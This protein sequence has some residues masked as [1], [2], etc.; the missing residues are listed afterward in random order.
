M[1]ETQP[2]TRPDFVC[3][4]CH[5]KIDLKGERYLVEKRF[6]AP[7][8]RVERTGRYL[9][10]TCDQKDHPP[11]IWHRPEEPKRPATF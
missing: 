6:N 1:S 11:G 7:L 10:E 4:S 2:Q 9:H 3:I 5:K 8:N